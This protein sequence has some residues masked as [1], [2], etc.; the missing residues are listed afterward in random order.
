MLKRKSRRRKTYRKRSF[1]SFIQLKP[2]RKRKRLFS[3]LFKFSLLLLLG[4]SLHKCMTHPPKDAENICQI[5]KEKSG[6]HNAAQKTSKKWG[7]PIHVMMATIYQESRFQGNARPPRKKL[8]GFLPGPRPSS[9]YGYAQ[10]LDETWD[11]YQKKNKLWGKNRDHFP[12][13]I[14]FVGW[15]YSESR[16]RN[17]LSAWDAKNLYLT[18]HEG[19]GGFSRGTHNK[20]AWLLKVASKVSKNASRYNQQYNGCKES[21]KRPWWLPK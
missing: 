20:K 6:W 18:Y 11:Y 12:H 10:A 16:T 3:L 14:E 19:H 9:A 8:L 1:F 13:A 15:Y 2:K 4:F 17:K 21:L 5:F 7:I